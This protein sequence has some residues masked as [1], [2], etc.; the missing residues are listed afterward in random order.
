MKTKDIVVGQEYAVGTASWSRRARVVE[1]GDIT[2]RVFSGAR[3]DWLG[4]DVTSKAVRVVYLH[5]DGESHDEVVPPG[6]VLHTWERE[7]EIQRAAARLRQEKERQAIDAREAAVLLNP[8]VW[9]AFGH[10]SAHA[11]N[12][13]VMVQ[14]PP[15][16][17]RWLAELLEKEL[18]S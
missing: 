14:L 3:W 9:N 4:H 15:A 7:L 8:V 1:V 6:K 16:A 17:A 5:A 18:P 2:R 10:A 13:V 11:S 12:G